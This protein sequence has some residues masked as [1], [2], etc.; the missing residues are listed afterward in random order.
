MKKPKWFDPKSE[1]FDATKKDAM[2]EFA[3]D[4]GFSLDSD[5][6]TTKAKVVAA[7]AIEWQKKYGSPEGSQGKMTARTYF[8]TKGLSTGWFGKLKRL[9]KKSWDEWDKIYA[10]MGGK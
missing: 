3:E 7:I 6:K 4:E 8:S 5:D 10:E 9:G 1:A 2:L